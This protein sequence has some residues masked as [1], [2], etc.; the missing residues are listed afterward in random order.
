MC[1]ITENKRVYIR[2][3]GCQMNVRDSQVI[4][5]LLVKDGFELTEDYLSARV[6]LF[7]TCSVRQ[8]A[9]ERVF[10]LIGEYMRRRDQ[11]PGSNREVPL[12]GILGCMAKNYAQGI[13]ERA[14]LVDFAVGPDDIDKVPAIIKRLISGKGDVTALNGRSLFSK[15]IWEVD[16]GQ[17]PEEI[18]HTN[19]HGADKCAYIVISEG[20][21]NFCSYC[22][23]PHVRGRLRHRHYKDILREIEEAIAFGVSS[24]LL[25]GQNVNA[26]KDGEIN[27]IKLLTLVDKLNGLSDFTFMTSH[28]KDAN[29]DLFKA[30]ATLKKLKKDL[31]LPLQSGSDKIL[32]LMNRGYTKRMY[33]ELAQN[34]RRIVS[35][36]RLSTDIIVGF[37]TENGADFKET[38]DFFKMIKFDSAFIFKYSPRPNTAAF[39]MPD[40][41]LK[42]EKERRHTLMLNLQKS[43]LAGACFFFFFFSHAYALN[44]ERVKV[45]Y[46]T[47]DYKGA[48]QEGNRLI[49]EDRYSSELYYFLGLSYL[50]DG[51]YTKAAESFKVV[52]NNLKE[53]RLKEEARIGLADT[54]LL[55]GDYNNAKN[56]YNELLAGNPRTKFK[57]QI[58][59][60]LSGLEPSKE[61]VYSVQ[62]GS[63]ANID[64][65]RNLVK[66]LNSS[67]YP[68]YFEERTQGSRRSY[69]VRVG[70]LNTR[71]EAEELVKRLSREGHPT[72]IFPE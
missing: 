9:E 10:S 22:I 60:R 45:Y 67:G 47:Q 15:K 43:I 4:S 44:I 8:H 38:F 2:T 41:V 72:K 21:S 28:P 20:C 61:G 34:Y 55:R 71:R 51:Q 23:V 66:K 62:V 35:G 14:P 12:I 52:I 5:G 29:L 48:I 50:K 49:A 40:D 46:L 65:A 69:R 32:K 7:N 1:K 3:F 36:G 70:K 27:F 25:L 19:F 58:Q 26:Y 30:M 37:P 17:R 59:Q 24:V 56:I 57:D 31:H 39:N 42:E 68:A 18:Y 63:F 53:S 33:L 54:Y 6:I 16:G 64:N 11:P 13:F